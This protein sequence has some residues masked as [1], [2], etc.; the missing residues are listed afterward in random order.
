MFWVI[1]LIVNSLIL[2]EE[3]G[4]PLS[5]STLSSEQASSRSEILYFMYKPL[6]RQSFFQLTSASS[7]P[8]FDG[9]FI[10]THF[11]GDLFHGL[12]VVIMAEKNFPVLGGQGIDRPAYQRSGSSFRSISSEGSSAPGISSFFLPEIPSARLRAAY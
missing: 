8:G 1:L 5:R 6:L 12:G 4:V 9:G 10:Q 3:S 11:D 7:Q 2:D